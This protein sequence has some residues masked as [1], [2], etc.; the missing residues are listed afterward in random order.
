MKGEGKDRE[1]KD[2]GGECDE[3]GGKNSRSS[4]IWPAV[5]TAPSVLINYWL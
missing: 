3:R 5:S 2:I 4:V 1:R